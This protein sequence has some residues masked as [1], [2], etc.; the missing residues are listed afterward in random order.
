M[1]ILMYGQSRLGAPNFTAQAAVVDLKKNN[2]GFLDF[3]NFVSL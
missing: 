2:Y 1:H 3:L